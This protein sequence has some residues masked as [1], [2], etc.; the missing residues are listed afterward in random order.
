M[1]GDAYIARS[2]FWD[3]SGGVKFES[4]MICRTDLVLDPDG[5][6]FHCSCSPSRVV[7]FQCPLRGEGLLSRGE[8]FTLNQFGVS[9]KGLN[10]GVVRPSAS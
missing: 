2:I 4:D 5:A 10:K 3:A 6:V 8:L 1:P 7:I 9:N